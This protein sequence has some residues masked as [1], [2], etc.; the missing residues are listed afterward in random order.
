M[1]RRP[2]TAWKVKEIAETPVA[3]CKVFVSRR[4]GERGGT[5]YKRRPGHERVMCLPQ[6]FELCTVGDEE[7]LNTWK[8][9]EASCGGKFG[10]FEGAV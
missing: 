4:S 1:S 6:Q 9:K 7:P 8:W 2:E 3:V 5:R 10:G